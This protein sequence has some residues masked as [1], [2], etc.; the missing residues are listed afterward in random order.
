MTV[1]DI[2]LANLDELERR[3]QERLAALNKGQVP[4]DASHPKIERQR[5]LDLKLNGADLEVPSSAYHSEAIQ[6]K[7]FDAVG[8][9]THLNDL[10]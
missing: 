9:M 7:T 8:P 6:S 1:A 4:R 2:L 10:N 5:L 3:E